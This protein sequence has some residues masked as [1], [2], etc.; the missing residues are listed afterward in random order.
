MAILCENDNLCRYLCD[1]DISNI[2]DCNGKIF[3]CINVDECW[4]NCSYVVYSLF[5]IYMCVFCFIL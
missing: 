1:N 5:I 2:G 4:I 3:E